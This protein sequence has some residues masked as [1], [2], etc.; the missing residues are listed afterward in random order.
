M[1]LPSSVSFFNPTKEPQKIAFL[2][3]CLSPAAKS[4]AL[5]DLP[6]DIS[7][8]CRQHL[9]RSVVH[10]STGRG[11][12]AT[13][14]HHKGVPVQNWIHLGPLRI[15][16]TAT[17]LHLVETNLLYLLSREPLLS[18]PDSI[19]FLCWSC[20]RRFAANVGRETQFSPQPVLFMQRQK[21][22]S[23]IKNTGIKKGNR[24]FI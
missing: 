4:D 6:Q 5:L 20:S 7:K 19:Y 1:H 9:S 3:L 16:K 13:L 22:Q 17:S 12:N 11:I 18:H 8:G 21:K 10:S 23:T 15:D 24:S 2:A 14:P